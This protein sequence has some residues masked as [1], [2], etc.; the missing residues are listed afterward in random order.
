MLDHFNKSCACLKKKNPISCVKT[1]NLVSVSTLTDGVRIAETGCLVG[2]CDEGTPLLEPNCPRNMPPT[3][4]QLHFPSN[5]VVPSNIIKLF[6]IP[7]N[8]FQDQSRTN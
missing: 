7:S 5:I 1:E 8:R 6:P 2:V 3:S 4:L